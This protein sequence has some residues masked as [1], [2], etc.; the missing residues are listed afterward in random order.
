MGTSVNLKN[1]YAG[2]KVEV[3]VKSQFV[4]DMMALIQDKLPGGLDRWVG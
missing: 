2:Y 3:V 1:K 4:Q